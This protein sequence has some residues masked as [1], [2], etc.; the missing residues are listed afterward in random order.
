MT[1]DKSI[2]RCPIVE[3]IRHLLGSHTWM[4]EICKYC[5]TDIWRTTDK[6]D[7]DHELRLRAAIH[8]EESWSEKNGFT[9]H[10]RDAAFLLRLLDDERKRR[11]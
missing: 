8:K 3:R 10:I 7:H 2:D 4:Y 5:T 1:N 11:R 6:S 9:V